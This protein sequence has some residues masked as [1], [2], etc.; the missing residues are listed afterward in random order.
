MT[1]VKEEP[2]ASLP[3]AGDTKS[4]GHPVASA[5]HRRGSELKDGP[6]ADCQKTRKE[7]EADISASPSQRNQGLR[8]SHSSLQ[9]V[10]KRPIS[11]TA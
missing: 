7:P 5:A 8:P 6:K 4:S 2:S 3:A 10:S 11:N 9:P 1:Q